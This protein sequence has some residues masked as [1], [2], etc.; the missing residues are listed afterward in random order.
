MVLSPLVSLSI[1][2]V[3]S[4]LEPR[5]VDGCCDLVQPSA[6]KAVTDYIDTAEATREADSCAMVVM[7]RVTG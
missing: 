1:D 7:T 3:M 5:D 4:S 2:R 6:R